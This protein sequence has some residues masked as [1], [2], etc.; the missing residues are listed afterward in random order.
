ME[1]IVQQPAHRVV[2]DKADHVEHE[3]TREARHRPHAGRVADGDLAG[4]GDDSGSETERR[5]FC[6]IV[7]ERAR[8]LV[9]QHEAARCAAGRVRRGR[10]AGEVMNCR[11][12]VCVHDDAA[13][14]RDDG[15]VRD[16][17]VGCDLQFVNVRRAGNR[18]V[19]R[20]ARVGGHGVEVLD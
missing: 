17:G 19:A 1:Q 10:H 14:D 8:I 9:E 3:Q 11:E 15:V 13:R 20:K 5:H 18:A 2:E 12:V 7:H 6:S 4:V 16:I